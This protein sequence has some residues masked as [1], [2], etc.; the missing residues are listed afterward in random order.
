MRHFSRSRGKRT[1]VLSGQPRLH[2]KFF[3][4]PDAALGSAPGSRGNSQA[5]QPIQL[6]EVEN[7]A[8]NLAAITSITSPIQISTKKDEQKSSHH[9]PT[10]GAS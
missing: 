9:C 2:V 7:Y 3:T 8:T 6:D 1:A 5:Q 10:P 4:K